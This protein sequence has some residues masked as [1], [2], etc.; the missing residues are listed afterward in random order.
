VQ[1][2]DNILAVSTSNT[3]V[4]DTQTELGWRTLCSYEQKKLGETDEMSEIRWEMMTVMQCKS[5]SVVAIDAC[6][7]AY[8]P[9]LY[10]PTQQF[11]ISY[12]G[13]YILAIC[14]CS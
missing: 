7:Q 11:S 9:P 2:S 1:K 4:T 12:S 13:M 6:C 10:R 3:N 5:F 8:A 14:W